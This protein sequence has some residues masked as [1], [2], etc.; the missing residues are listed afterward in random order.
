MKH[1]PIGK[2]VIPRIL[3]CILAF[4]LLVGCS[5]DSD[6]LAP[7]TAL[8]DT[9]SGED[10]GALPLKALIAPIDFDDLL[11]AM[12][13]ISVQRANGDAADGWYDVDFETVEYSLLDLNN[14]VSGLIS[15]AELPAGIYDKIYLQLAEGNRILIDGEEFDLSPPPGPESQI[16]IFHQFELIEGEEFN[17]ALVFDPA[18]LVTVNGKGIY[19]LKPVLRIQETTSVGDIIGVVIPVNA[20]AMITTVSSIGTVV[21]Y[22][23]MDTGEFILSALPA[24]TYTLTF[25]STGDIYY[26]SLGL[27]GVEVT[28]GNTTDIGTINMMQPVK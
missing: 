12:T 8:L 3:T 6:L 25:T 1:L 27:P 13:G 10:A 4:S 18:S 16:K 2:M 22:A 5:G 17:A 7:D 28:A 19:S 14:V 26:P 11:L 21:T 20:E 24:G 9:V 15:N 23:D